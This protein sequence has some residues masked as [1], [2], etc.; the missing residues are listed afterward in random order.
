MYGSLINVVALLQTNDRP[1]SILS[2]NTAF[3]RFS[4]WEAAGW[5]ISFQN[6]CVE[7]VK[8]ATK[9]LRSFFSLSNLEA[10][11]SFLIQQGI[12]CP[13]PRYVIEILLIL[14]TLISKC[15]HSTCH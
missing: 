11:N 10:I 14:Y 4:S 3:C 7:R 15:L 13:L 5:G 1:I 8:H 9:V 2:T 6:T 12:L